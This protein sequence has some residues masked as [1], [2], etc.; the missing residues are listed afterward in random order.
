MERAWVKERIWYSGALEVLNPLRFHLHE[1]IEAAE[2]HNKAAKI[3]NMPLISEQKI[4][5]AKTALEEAEMYF[6]D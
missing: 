5:A 2:S 1:L 4:G 3:L 6:G